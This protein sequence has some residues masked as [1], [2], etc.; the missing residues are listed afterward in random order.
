[1]SNCTRVATEFTRPVFSRR[2]CRT[3]RHSVT[4]TIAWLALLALMSGCARS[5][6]LIS[7]AHVGHTLTAWHDTPEQSGLFVVA[8]KETEQALE[9]YALAEVAKSTPVLAR[10]HIK[11]VIHSLNPD[12]QPTGTGAGYGA[13]RALQG[14]IDHLKFA[15]VSDDA[16]TNL[17]QSAENFESHAQATLDQLLVALGA[18]RLVMTGSDADFS[19]DLSA[20]GDVLKTAANG[21]DIDND[22]VIGNVVGESGLRQLRQQ[23]SSLLGNEVAPPYHPVGRRYLF[24]LVKL[25]NGRWVYQFDRTSSDGDGTEGGGG[26]GSG[27]GGG[28]GGGGSGY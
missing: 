28:G 27:G 16:S 12:L 24:G 23:L 7:H 6:P 1:M 26:G 13:V 15:A 22:G 19:T 8:E 4:G 3:L 9:E 11:N 21:Q 17:R 5:V 2:E 10:V 14:S 20:L 25:P 18:A